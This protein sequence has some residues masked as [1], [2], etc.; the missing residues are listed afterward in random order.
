MKNSNLKNKQTIKEVLKRCPG[1]DEIRNE[2]LKECKG[3]RFIEIKEC[4]GPPY[5][6]FGCTSPGVY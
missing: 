6:K 3:V 1:T 5:P 4:V 2:I